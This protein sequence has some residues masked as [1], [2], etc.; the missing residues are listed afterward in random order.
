MVAP[1]N[2]TALDE[3]DGEVLARLAD[4]SEVATDG[5]F[6][7]GIPLQA[8]VGIVFGRVAVEPPPPPVTQARVP[9]PA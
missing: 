6:V 9:T 1:A 5:V 4:G 2:V 8:A 3:A 7:T